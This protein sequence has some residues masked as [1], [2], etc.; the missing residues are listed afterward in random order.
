MPATEKDIKEGLEVQAQKAKY[1]GKKTQMSMAAFDTL[2]GELNVWLENNG[3]STVDN[4]QDKK[5]VA[6][7]IKHAGNLSTVFVAAPNGNIGTHAVAT[8]PSLTVAE[9]VTPRY[10]LLREV[11]NA[12]ARPTVRADVARVLGIIDKAHTIHGAN[13]AGTQTLEQIIKD[14]V[15]KVQGVAEIQRVHAAVKTHYNLTL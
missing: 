1:K 7:V 10:T 2:V 5:R 4:A 11:H 3:R 13:F 14:L 6:T 12:T 8:L 15:D 9:P